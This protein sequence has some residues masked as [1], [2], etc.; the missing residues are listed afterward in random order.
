MLALNIIKNFSISNDS[1]CKSTYRLRNN[2]IPKISY[3]FSEQENIKENNNLFDNNNKLF[4][5]EDS[6]DMDFIN[7][8]NNDIDEFQTHIND[9]KFREN[10]VKKLYMK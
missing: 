3:R 8:E 2:K 5:E 6:F 10:Y 9:I 1:T 4:D 7:E